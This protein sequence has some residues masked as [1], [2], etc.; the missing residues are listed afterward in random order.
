[1]A[2]PQQQQPRRYI[3]IHERTPDM[4]ILFVSSGVRQTLRYEPGEIVGRPSLDFTV[5]SKEGEE[6]RRHNSS[7]TDDNV[8]MT[9]ML[10]KHKTDKP[11]PV[12]AITFA[13]G[14]VNLIMA[15]LIPSISMERQY[16]DGI[17]V[18]SFYFNLG[19]HHST[20][21][22]GPSNIEGQGT[23]KNAVCSMRRAHQ[24]CFVLGD[25]GSSNAND[26]KGAK[27]MFVTDSIN[28]ILNADSSDIQGMPFLSLVALEDII[29]ATMFLDKTLNNYDIAFESLNLL[30]NPSE[31]RKEENPQCVAVE[32]MAIGS[33][34]GVIMLCQ[35]AQSKSSDSNNNNNGYMS[36]E[37]IISS[38]PWT[39][40]FA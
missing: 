22:H 33:D 24:A 32:F 14:N 20:N 27:V 3:L 1:M 40:D 37:D 8:M 39:S 5:T 10:I 2:E 15:T 19:G 30:V 13:C 4:P 25:F 9:S 26:E 11:V 38:D 31:E 23:H 29:K 17:S 28:R 12:H 36:L 18:Q 34:D 16:K 6:Y 21:K 7:Q 35:L